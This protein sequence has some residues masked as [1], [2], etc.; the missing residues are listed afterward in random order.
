MNPSQL[1]LA[2]KLVGASYAR[3]AGEAGMGQQSRTSQLL[4]QGKMP[5]DGW[6]DREIEF[7]LQQLSQ[8]DSNNF[9]ANAGVGERE[10][11]V[12]SSLVARRHYGLGHGIG[13]SGDLTEV[14]PKA[15]GSSIINRL[16]NSMLLDLIRRSGV[17]RTASC[18]LV[19]VATGMALT[20]TMLSLRQARPT[21]KF[22]LWSRI[23]Q[24]SCFK[25]ILTAGLEPVVVELLQRGEELGTDLEAIAREIER[26]GSEAVLCVMTTTSCFAPRAPDDL[27]GVA[28][29][30]QEQDI[31]HV[32]N[33]AY[34]L[35]SSKCSHLINEAIRVGRLDLFVQSCDKNLLVP[36]GGAVIAGPSAGVVAA[37]A[38]SYPGRA[39][40][41]PAVDVFITLLSMG[42]SGWKRLLA[43]RKDLFGQLKEEM[44]GLASRHGIKVLDSRANNISLA[45]TL[46]QQGKEATAVGS[47]LFTRGVSGTRVVTGK[48]SKIIGGVHFEGWG[49]HT[50]NCAQAYLTAAAAI[51]A[52]EQDVKLFIKRVDKVLGK[53]T[54]DSEDREV[55]AVSRNTKELMM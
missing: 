16:T 31:P 33:N 43:Q 53:L 55:L 39:S 27:P 7:L 28:Q 25:S 50:N 42:V 44:G 20:L 2:A 4:E 47:M 12:Y 48:D 36:V 40:S 49:A 9:P 10:G 18:F 3:Q 14:Q 21:A 8:M 37:V 52:E 24:K 29:L 23:D 19:P 5:Q 13:R 1:E 34:G 26:L 35:Q 46:Q 41:S 22:V 15:A 30:C 32:V 38:A 11:R 45:L 54:E 6:Q 51:G 17:E